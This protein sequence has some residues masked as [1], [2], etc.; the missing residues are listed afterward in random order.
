MCLGLF[1]CL[2]NLCLNKC[3]ENSKTKT[4]VVVP[5]EVEGVGCTGQKGTKTSFL[6]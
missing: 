4:S 3:L 6:T 1:L 5:V 2:G